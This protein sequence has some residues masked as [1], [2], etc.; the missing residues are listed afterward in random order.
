[1]C[2]ARGGALGSLDCSGLCRVAG[3]TGSLA[4]ALLRALQRGGLLKVSEHEAGRVA[5]DKGLHPMADRNFLIFLAVVFGFI[6]V[7]FQAWNTYPVFLNE[8][9]GLNE[10]VFGGLM[11]FNAVLILLFEM[12]LT[13]WAERFSPLSVI[14]WGAMSVGFGYVVLNFGHGL[15]IA[16]LSM[17]LW[18]FGE[19]LALPFAGGWVANRAGVKHRGKYMGLY[20]MVWGLAFIVAPPV[21][22]WIYAQ[23]SPQALWWVTLAICAV[24]WVALEALSRRLR[25]ESALAPQPPLPKPG[26]GEPD[27]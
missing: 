12:L 7:F 6:F 25:R 16:V 15:P 27:S 5:G 26:E 14:G 18:T 1:L 11:A 10:A 19:M 20:T 4:A 2:R 17:A 9:Y 13:H 24:T 21:G 23:W 8:V 3:A 22:S